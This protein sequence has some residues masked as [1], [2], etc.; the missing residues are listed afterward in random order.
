MAASA[1]YA[2]ASAASRIYTMPTGL[3]GSI[4][5]VMLHMDLS[6]LLADAGVKPT[7][8]FAGAHKVDGNPYEPL[9]D[10]VRATFQAEIDAFYGLFVQAVAI[11]R[12]RRMTEQGVRETEARIF[13]GDDAVRIGLADEIATFD[14]VIATLA[15]PQS[16]SALVGRAQASSSGGK[17]LMNDET[18]TATVAAPT[19]TEAKPDAKEN[20]GATAAH[21]QPPAQTVADAFASFNGKEGAQTAVRAVPAPAAAAAPAEAPAAAPAAPAPLEVILTE[22][23]R[24]AELYALGAQ[25]ARLGVSIDVPKAVEDGT[26]VDVLRKAVIDTAAARDEATAVVATTTATPKTAAGPNTAGGGL[27][28]AAAELAAKQMAGR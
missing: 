28:R 6:Q 18:S 19:T 21:N 5:V 11:G 3:S 23:R 2:I 7:F 15:G 24:A 22:R 4:G 8:I 17:P 1:A 12:G 13:M 10:G 27:Q 25:A 9:P 16:S 14:E 26:S 20:A